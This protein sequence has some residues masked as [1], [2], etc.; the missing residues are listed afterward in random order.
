MRYYVGFSVANRVT[1]FLRISS[2]VCLKTLS[3][4]AD[5]GW[6]F[7]ANAPNY[8]TCTETYKAGYYFLIKSLIAPM[9]T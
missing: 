1:Y 6:V 2:T 9:Q 8:E 3:A 7:Q 5:P 4:G